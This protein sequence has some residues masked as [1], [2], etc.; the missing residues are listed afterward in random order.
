MDGANGWQLF[1]RITLPMIARSTYI[2]WILM[3]IFCIG[4]F[5]SIYLLTGGG[6]VGSTNTLVVLAY[7]TVFGNFQTGP[8]LAIAVMMTLVSVLVSVVLYRRIKKVE[9]L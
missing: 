3:F 7:E 9:I 4:D 2:S 5:Q 1:R 8:G 6:P